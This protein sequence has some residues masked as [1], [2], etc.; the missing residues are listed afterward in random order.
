LRRK[1]KKRELVTGYRAT[2]YKCLAA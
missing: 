2:S 1:G